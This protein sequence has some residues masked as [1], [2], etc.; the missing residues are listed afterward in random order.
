MRNNSNC[1]AHD[2]R[3]RPRGGFALSGYLLPQHRQLQRRFNSDPL[4]CPTSLEVRVDDPPQNSRYTVRR[5][6]V[7]PIFR[8]Y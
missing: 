5:V 8:N 7:R 6:A 2:Y 3:T 4:P 1:S